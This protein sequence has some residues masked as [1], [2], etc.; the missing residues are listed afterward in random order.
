MSMISKEQAR[1]LLLGLGNSTVDVDSRRVAAI[2]V[3]LDLL[4]EDADQSTATSDLV[5]TP[6]DA[7]QPWGR[8]PYPPYPAVEIEN[9]S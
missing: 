4:T 5:G 6:F 1:I 3:V 2:G 8:N 7:D 9:G